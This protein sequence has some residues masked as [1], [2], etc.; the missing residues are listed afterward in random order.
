MRT[1]ITVDEHILAAAKKRAAE[2]HQTLSQVVEDALRTALM[3][4]T[5]G[6]QP[7]RLQW[8][9]VDGGPLPGVDIADRNDLYERM[10]GRG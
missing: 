6:R 7:F 3:A 1:T 5:A 9:T 4:R 10:E 8:P 2:T